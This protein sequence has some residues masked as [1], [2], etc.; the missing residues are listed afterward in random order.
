MIESMLI[1]I[2]CFNIITCIGVVLFAK[3]KI[4]QTR[5]L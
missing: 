4:K 1:A 3:Y 2:I 5:G